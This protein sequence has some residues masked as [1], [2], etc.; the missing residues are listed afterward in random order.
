MIT[1]KRTVIAIHTHG[2]AA[3][4]RQPSVHQATPLPDATEAAERCGDVAGAGALNPASEGEGERGGIG[5]AMGN[6][7][8]R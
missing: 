7:F 8:A 1:M 6:A 3:N 2:D 5:S 4:R